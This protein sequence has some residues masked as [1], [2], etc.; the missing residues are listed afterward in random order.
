[1]LTKRFG[2]DTGLLLDLVSYMIVDEEN[3]GQ[4]YLDFA[5]CHPLFSDGMR[6]YSDSKVSRFLSSFTKDQTTGFLDDWNRHRDHKQRIYNLLKETMIRLDARPNYM[7][8]PA[9][10]RE[11]EKA[12]ERCDALSAQLLALQN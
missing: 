6:I 2:D 4:Y 12:Q 3:A 5:F 1:M 11:L 8:V 7:T 10:I 9:A